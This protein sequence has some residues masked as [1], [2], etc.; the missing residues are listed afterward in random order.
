MNSNKDGV[1]GPGTLASK[2]RAKDR[3]TASVKAAWLMGIFILWAVAILGLRYF[4]SAPQHWAVARIEIL[5]THDRFDPRVW[6]QDNVHSP[7]TSSVKEH[8]E[9]LKSRDLAQ[10]V[11]ANLAP[12]RFEELRLALREKVPKTD[13]MAADF[14]SL[15]SFRSNSNERAYE[16]ADYVCDNLVVEP[17]T[18]CNMIDVSVKAPNQS[19]ANELLSLYLRQFNSANLEK[20]RM[21]TLESVE[22]LKQGVKETALQLKEAEAALLDFVI[23]NGFCATKESGLGRVFSVINRHVRGAQSN[24]EAQN[25]GDTY[26]NGEGVASKGSEQKELIDRMATDLG[27][28]EAEQSGLN[29]T[30]GLNHPKMM[31]LAGKITFLRD[32]IEYFRRGASLGV[33]A[34]S[35]ETV[36][37]SSSG[38]EHSKVS[39]AKAKSLEEQYADLKR[40]VD[41]KADFHRMVL[42]EAQ[43][44]SVKSRTIS[45]N[46]VVIDGPRAGKRGWWR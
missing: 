33:P 34:K 42:K 38:R 22:N 46:I 25:V 9:A 28:L 35:Q 12:E 13:V 29:S 15:A 14:T 1:T 36:S 45:N 3:S 43:I 27:K 16:P 17:V 44:W 37:A 26:G 10:L 30:L 8:A 40:D 41:Y 20:R 21:Q 32:R 2:P 4:S 6:F 18:G 24:G 19:L 23:Q 5:G 39:L 7:I 31:A 11:I